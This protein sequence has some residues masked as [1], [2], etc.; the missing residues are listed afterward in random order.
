MAGLPFGSAEDKKPRPSTVEIKG[1]Q[2]GRTGIFAR[3]RKRGGRYKIL[4]NRNP[5]SEC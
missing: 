4:L 5:R 1:T 2:M 3:R